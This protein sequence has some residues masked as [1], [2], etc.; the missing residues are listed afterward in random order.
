LRDEYTRLCRRND[1]DD[2]RSRHQQ[3]VEMAVEF[4]GFAKSGLSAAGSVCKVAKDFFPRLSRPEKARALVAEAVR[5]AREAEGNPA[6]DQITKL[7]KAIEI[8]QR[9][10]DR[11]PST[12]EAMLLIKGELLHGL[13]LAGVQQ[14]RSSAERELADQKRRDEEE[15]HRSG[16]V[17]DLQNMARRAVQKGSKHLIFETAGK[18]LDVLTKEQAGDPDRERIAKRSIVEALAKNGLIVEAQAKATAWNAA[19]DRVQRLETERRYNDGQDALE[20]ANGFEVYQEKQR[21][22]F[23]RWAALR[24][25]NAG[26]ICHSPGERDPRRYR[27]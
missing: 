15:R 21:W 12:D 6:H 11:Y 24:Q 8:L 5:L 18:A 16:I 25:V 1:L 4:L 19:I 27:A 9:V 13:T 22:E 2:R 14:R 3:E 20:L 7:G 17:R 23:L 10:R 26:H